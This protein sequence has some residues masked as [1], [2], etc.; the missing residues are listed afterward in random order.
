MN[1]WF[2][3]IKKK[4]ILSLIVNYF[5]LF[6]QHFIIFN[7]TFTTIIVRAFNLFLSTFNKTRK[8]FRFQRSFISINIRISNHS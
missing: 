3:I 2:H 8:H 6:P 4:N 1:S 7:N 5:S